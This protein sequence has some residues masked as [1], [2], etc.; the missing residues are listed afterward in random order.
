MMANY[1]ICG[2]SCQ[3]IL[4]CA[5]VCSRI[6]IFRICQFTGITYMHAKA[7]SD[8]ALALIIKFSGWFSYVPKTLAEEA[9]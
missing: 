9:Q 3:Y 7:R 4:N 1:H 5:T 6:S 8:K 2:F